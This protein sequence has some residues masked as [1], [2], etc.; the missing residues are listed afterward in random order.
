MA[1][2]LIRNAL[3][4]TPQ[5]RHVRI[6]GQS[7][8]DHLSWE[9]ADE[10]AGLSTRAAKNLLDPFYCG[11]EAGR[12]LGLGLSRA[13]RFV[14]L[15]GGNLTWRHAPGG[16]TIFRVELPLAPVPEKQATQAASPPDFRAT[17]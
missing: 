4:A 14:S 8:P 13:A 17:A 12:G 10:G 3:E 11:R 9:V 1:D 6:Q 5:G 2:I 15:S 7:T 16:G